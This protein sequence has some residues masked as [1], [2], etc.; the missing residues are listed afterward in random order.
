MYHH[1]RSGQ[2]GPHG[3]LV[4]LRV[5]EVCNLDNEPVTLSVVRVHALALRRNS[6]LVTHKHAVDGHNGVNGVHA[7]SLVDLV[8]IGQGLGYAH[9]PHKVQGA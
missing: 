4:L 2:T 9:V 5:V 1:L 7:V 3:E 8:V 6:K